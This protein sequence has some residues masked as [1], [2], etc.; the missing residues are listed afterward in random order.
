MRTRVRAVTNTDCS[1]ICISPTVRFSE[2]QSLRRTE[3][4]SQRLLAHAEA[5]HLKV[6]TKDGKIR[7]AVSEDYEASPMSS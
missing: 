1:G 5:S 6:Y 4:S 2:A 7:A 3:V